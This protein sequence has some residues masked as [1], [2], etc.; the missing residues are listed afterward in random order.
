[1]KKFHC[2][3]EHN[4][5]EGRFA[6][7]DVEDCIDTGDCIDHLKK[8]FPDHHLISIEDLAYESQVECYFGSEYE[9][10]IEYE[11]KYLLT[12]DPSC[13]ILQV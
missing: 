2:T 1:M 12:F 9:A 13:V 7:V 5:H 4:D 6:F 10:G 11:Q 8:E 3:L